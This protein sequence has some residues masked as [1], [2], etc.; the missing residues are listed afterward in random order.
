MF[1][2]R[3]QSWWIDLYEWDN[4]KRPEAGKRKHM[5]TKLLAAISLK[6]FVGKKARKVEKKVGKKVRKIRRVLTCIAF[7]CTFIAG[8]SLTVYLVYKHSDEIAARVQK[9]KRRNRLLRILRLK[10]KA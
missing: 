7:A 8:C 5:L 2:S 10:K 3:G 4:Q 9:R 6:N 1:C